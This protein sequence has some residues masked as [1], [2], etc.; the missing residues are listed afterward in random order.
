MIGDKKR[1]P[2]H[3]FA[4]ADI[5]FQNLAQN[6]EHQCCVVSGESGAGTSRAKH[7][8]MHPCTSEEEKS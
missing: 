4:M 5:A 7:I 2:P 1:H 8:H 3:L 6:K